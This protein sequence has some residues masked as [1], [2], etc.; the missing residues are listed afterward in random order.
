MESIFT[1]GDA[2]EELELMIKGAADCYFFDEPK[3]PSIRSHGV[4]RH[5]NAI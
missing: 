1:Q 2:W 3:P 4:S 5:L